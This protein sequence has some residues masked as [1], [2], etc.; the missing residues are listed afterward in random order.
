MR[1]VPIPKTGKRVPE[2]S[3]KERIENFQ[4][5]RKPFSLS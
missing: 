3:W 5:Q 2:G 4:L 1:Q